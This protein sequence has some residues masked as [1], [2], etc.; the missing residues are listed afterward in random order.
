VSG[1][2][3]APGRPKVARAGLITGIML[4]IGIAGFIDEALFHQLLQWHNFYWNTDLTGRIRSDGWF[5]VASMLVALWGVARLWQHGR[6]GTRSRD[7]IVAGMLIGGGGFNAY[8]G[9][10]Q[11]VVLHLHLVNEL[12]CPS[13]QNGSNS[14]LTCPAD[15]PYETIWIAIA[16]AVAAAGIARWRR[17][18]WR[19]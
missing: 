15:I 11:H 6:A 2:A 10:V 17:A 5:H 16:L 3:V 19:A 1:A 14:V 12:V 13:P 18:T 8:D 7:V 4:G 9:I